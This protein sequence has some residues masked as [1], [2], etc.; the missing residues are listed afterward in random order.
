MQQAVVEVTLVKNI[1]IMINRS[2]LPW[3][4]QALF[5]LLIFCAPLFV[6]AAGRCPNPQWCVADQPNELDDPRLRNA[7]HVCVRTQSNQQ[8][9]STPSNCPECDITRKTIPGATM[10][11]QHAYA[12]SNT[13]SSESSVPNQDDK[14]QKQQERIRQSQAISDATRNARD[15]LWEQYKSSSQQI[16]W[17]KGAR[18]REDRLNATSKKVDASQDMLSRAQNVLTWKQ[19]IKEKED[20][21]AKTKA[22]IARLEEAKKT[23]Q[24]S[25]RDVENANREGVY[26]AWAG[27]LVGVVEILDGAGVMISAVL[28]PQYSQLREALKRGRKIGKGAAAAYTTTENMIDKGENGDISGALV[29]G[30]KG[31]SAA[32]GAAVAGSGSKDQQFKDFDKNFKRSV[33][34]AEIIDDAAKGNTDS[35]DYKKFKRGVKE[36]PVVGERGGDLL[37]G[38]EQVFSGGKKV[39]EMSD[40]E[41]RILTRAVAQNANFGEI[42]T[43][44]DNR[45]TLERNTLA[46]LETELYRLKEDGPHSGRLN[47]Y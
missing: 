34:G 26:Y 12:R 22:T 11:I 1:K 39:S 42:M 14:N 45:L 21:I 6:Y 44:V 36:L 38:G 46:A 25:Q 47:A 17:D 40:E 37:D 24:S 2:V 43:R 32:T 29:E 23:M 35:A 13:G 33:D 8:V 31:L 4:Y 5:H 9:T 10:C 28:P 7:P 16:D 18:E 19:K 30:A 3:I 15:Q 20:L 41:V 27:Q